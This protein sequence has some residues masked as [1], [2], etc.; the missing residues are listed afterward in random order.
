MH[1]YPS[2]HCEPDKVAFWE[3][4]PGRR[5]LGD[6]DFDR[7]LLRVSPDTGKVGDDL[8]LSCKFK[9]VNQEKHRRCP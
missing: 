8:D 9:R 5:D 6:A 2:C 4:A 1:E 3:G 7:V